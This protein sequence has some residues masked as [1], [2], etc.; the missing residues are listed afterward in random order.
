ML[1]SLEDYIVEME[2]RSA[3]QKP[4]STSDVNDD[5]WAQLQQKENDLVLAAE[6]GKALLDSKEELKRQHEAAIEEYQRKLEAVE[7]DRHVL[8]RRLTNKESELD[9]KI[10]E[11]QND[12]TTLTEKLTA[13]DNL[14]KQCEREKGNLVAELNA[15]NSRLTAQLKEATSVENRLQQQVQQLKEQCSLSKSTLYDHMNSVGGLRDE[16]DMLSEKNK[17]L[18]RRLHITSSER[19]SFANALEE[20]SDRILI[21]ERHAREQDIRYQHNIK[22]LSMPQDHM[23]IDERLHE[24]DLSEP[25][26]SQECMAVYRQL[27][28]LVQQLKSH[29]DDDSGLHSDCSTTSLDDNSQFAT[30]LLSEVAQELVSLVLDTDAVRLIERL[31]EAH[32]EI[33]ERDLELAKRQEKLMEL[34]SRV[35]VCDVELQAA[36]EDLIRAR[37]DAVN[38]SAQ[39]E[40][41]TK[42]RQDRDIAIERKTK[43]EIE[44]AKTRMDLMQ[45]NGQLMEAIQQKVE[46][47]QQL[48]QWQMDVQELLEEQVK[49]KLTSQEVKL[50][51]TMQSSPVAPPRRRLLSFLYR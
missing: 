51:S 26:L 10:V 37:N 24:M 31:E 44:L 27:R 23:S 36:K 2:K 33:Q 9:A 18:E 16:L 39:D 30:G 1:Q 19:D 22:E 40:I 46:L 47:S 14:L 49:N 7:Q 50:R 43:L 11:L 32:R 28:S 21:L 15:Q 5:L 12:I 38:T 6:L 45:A 3:I 41:V 13:K 34:S 8:K 17:E 25:T 29:Q 20:A 42:A 4:S 48:E 35:S